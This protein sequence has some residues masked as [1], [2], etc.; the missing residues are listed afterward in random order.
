MPMRSSTCSKADRY[1]VE[2][3]TCRHALGRAD[4]LGRAHR[5]SRR[6][7]QRQQHGAGQVRRGAAEGQGSSHPYASERM[8]FGT[9]GPVPSAFNGAFHLGR[10]GC[11][12][13][14]SAAS[15][16]DHHSAARANGSARR[17]QTR[18]RRPAAGG[19]MTSPAPALVWR[20]P[21]VYWHYRQSLR[22]Q[23]DRIP[24]PTE[25]NSH[26]KL[27]RSHD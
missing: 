16:A 18:H 12:G 14:P 2:R 21:R 15:G 4:V 20:E 6:G 25:S 17:R 22:S 9:L 11:G 5:C 7:A 10:V 27:S 24:T 1:A 8:M 26:D 3:P 13:K 19:E 23:I